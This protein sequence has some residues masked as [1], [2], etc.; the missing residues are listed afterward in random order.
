MPNWVKHALW[1]IIVLILLAKWREVSQWV[2]A[3]LGAFVMLVHQALFGWDD[4]L[5]HFAFL[6]IL[7]VAALGAW[8]LWL[9]HRG[10]KNP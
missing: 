10:S 3:I 9:E 2:M 7:V 6:G 1:A 8:R 4:P 5:Y